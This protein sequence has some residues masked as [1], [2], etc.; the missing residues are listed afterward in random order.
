MSSSLCWR[1]I[2]A[3]ETLP[4]A[5]KFALQKRRFEFPRVFGIEDIRYLEGLSDAGIEGAQA[6]IE[7]INQHDAVELYL[8]F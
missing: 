7:L 1:P 2:P 6:L 3:G 4:D 8:E 5:L